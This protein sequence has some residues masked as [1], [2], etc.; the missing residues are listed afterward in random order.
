[1]KDVT[2][3]ITGSNRDEK[4]YLIALVHFMGGSVREKCTAQ[5]THLVARTV[6]T[7][8]YRVGFS[9]YNYLR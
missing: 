1:M 7:E 5:I 3:C 4:K 9:L 6:Q 8:E 2:V